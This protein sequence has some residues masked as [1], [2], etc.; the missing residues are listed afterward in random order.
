M[1]LY[2]THAEALHGSGAEIETRVQWDGTQAD[3]AKTRKHYNSNLKIPR[4]H[5]HTEEVDV[6]TVKKDLID[7]LNARKV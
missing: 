3:A 1:K 6:P 2:R 7:F 5:I 4:D